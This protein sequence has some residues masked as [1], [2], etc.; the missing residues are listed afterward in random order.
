MSKIL[1]ISAL[2]PPEPTVSAM[3]SKDLA[4]ELSLKNEVVVLCPQPTRPK[5]FQFNYISDPDNYKVIR[6][7]SYT[8]PSSNIIGRFCESFSFGIQCVKYIYHNSKEIDCIYINSW[9][10]LSQYLIVKAA[11]KIHKPCVMHIQDVYPESLVNKLPIGKHI[12]YKLL[13]PIDRYSIKNSNVIIG[14]SKNMK[15]LLLSTRNIPSNKIVI[16]ANWQ[17]EDD[18]IQF[19][20]F[21]KTSD[22]SHPFTFMYLGNNGPL[23]GVDFLINS[24][25]KALIPNSKLIIAGTGSRTNACKELVKVLGIKN[26]EFLPVP[27]KMVPS[28]QDKADV[29]LLPVKQNGAKSSIPSKLPAYMFS[30]K[31][32]IGSL[33]LDSDTANAITTSGCGIVV[34][35]ENEMKLIDAMKQITEWS[36]QIREEKGNAGFEFAKSNFSKKNNLQKVISVIESLI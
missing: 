28:I 14:I 13:L 29:M 27:E 12:V 20:N 6:L 5:G 16:V 10:L 34:E 35:P 4:E 15:N 33:D 18:F 24:F 3:L 23:A 8:C 32:I 2:F 26:I 36:I 25:F 31:P 7:N 21:K 19:K 9:P 1:I 17:N 30:A 11:K 22:L